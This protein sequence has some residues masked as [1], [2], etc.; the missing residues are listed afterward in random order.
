MSRYK[1]VLIKLSGGGNIFR[2][3]VAD[4][5]GI[6]RAEADNIGTYISAHTSMELD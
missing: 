3:N 2:G 1:R 4:Q 6:A 5:W